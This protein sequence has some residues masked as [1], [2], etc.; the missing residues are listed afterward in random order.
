MVYDDAAHTV[1]MYLDTTAGTPAATSG[2][3]TN[4]SGLFTIGGIAR[5]TYTDGEMGQCGFWNRALSVD[6][7]TA[8]YNSGKGLY[9]DELSDDLKVDL[10][11]YWNLTEESGVRYDS[12][13]AYH[14]SDQNLVDVKRVGPLQTVASTSYVASTGKW[15]SRDNFRMPDS[16]TISMWVYGFSGY[17]NLPTGDPNMTYMFYAGQYYPYQTAANITG[18]GYLGGMLYGN[19]VGA[20]EYKSAG[21]FYGNWIDY[22]Y[23]SNSWHFFTFSYDA[24]T[25]TGQYRIDDRATPIIGETLTEPAWRND[26]D[27]LYLVGQPNVSTENRFASYGIWNKVLSQAEHQSIYN[28]GIGKKYSDL[29]AADKVGLVAYWNLDEHEANPYD[30]DPVR[31]DSHGSNHL[32]SHNVP[33][34][35]NTQ[36]TPS[37]GALSVNWEAANGQLLSASDELYDLSGGFTVAGWYYTTEY[38]FN[39][40]P[41]RRF[42][43][44]GKPYWAGG[45]GN[46]YASNGNSGPQILFFG[47]HNS[48]EYP[49]GYCMLPMDA[50]NLI[51]LWYDPATKK[52]YMRVNNGA[53]EES[54]TALTGAHPITNGIY[55]EVGGEGYGYA[56]AGTARNRYSDYAIWHR[57]LTDDERDE[58]YN[59]GKGKFYDFAG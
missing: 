51:V 3:L 52:A 10:V 39:T 8:L 49:Q 15:L 55:L 31:V 12:H 33:Y 53:P 45:T 11:S 25:R 16:F 26:G 17:P 38:D 13:G 28:G 46:I 42:F 35:L 5:A 59:L 54:T 4:K 43:S 1:T 30:L 36:H 56:L 6:D 58:L 47:A 48:S 32:T 24:T 18:G 9:Y 2:T 27:W 40:Y 29:T 37:G 34:A 19:N 14:L 21:G 20:G 44:M 41:Q 50:W 22:S 57:V 7:I 23:W